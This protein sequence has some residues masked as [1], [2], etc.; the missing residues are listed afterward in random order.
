VGEKAS[1]TLCV[2]VEF[3]GRRRTWRWRSAVSETRRSSEIQSW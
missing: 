1:E 3:H 2:V